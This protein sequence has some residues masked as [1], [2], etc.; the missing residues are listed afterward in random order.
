MSVLGPFHVEPS[1]HVV[2]WLQD[3]LKDT[4]KA[5]LNTTKIEVGGRGGGR[6]RREGRGGGRGRREGRADGRTDGE[7]EGEG[8]RGVYQE[9]KLL[10]ILIPEDYLWLKFEHCDV[11]VCTCFCRRRWN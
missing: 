7:G 4:R 2:L 3:L 10:L 5:G 11:L 1:V 8:G 9:Y 6:K